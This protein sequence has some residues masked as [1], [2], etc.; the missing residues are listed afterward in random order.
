MSGPDSSFDYQRFVARRER[1]ANVTLALCVAWWATLMVVGMGSRW[2]VPMARLKDTALWGDLTVDRLLA[3]GAI[4]SVVVVTGGPW[5]VRNLRRPP[6]LFLLLRDF[7][8]SAA[9]ELATAYVRNHGAAWGYWLTLEN[10]DL[11]AVDSVG[12]EVETDPDPDD[13]NDRNEKLPVGAWWATSIALGLVSTTMLLLYYLDSAPLQWMR[14]T[15]DHFGSI[16][17]LAFVLGAIVGICG[18]WFATALTIR[19][20]LLKVQ[21]TA[22][23]PGRI[24][25]EETCQRVLDIIVSRVRRRATTLTLGPLPVIS[26]SDGSWKAAVLRCIAEARLVVF[27][28]TARETEALKWEMDQ[29]RDRFDPRRTLYIE[30][31]GEDLCIT[32]GTGEPIA[33]TSLGGEEDRIEAAV[34]RMLVGDG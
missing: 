26:V 8:S 31:G 30:L 17:E 2:W 27:I 16:G 4:A 34:G 15:A 20:V 28:I 21:R 22:V 3:Y 18:I 29:V 7:Q 19:W 32:D 33:D 5:L 25:S 14:R 24:N 11:R 6:Q 13:E 12:G 10:A 9:A 23:L 1:L